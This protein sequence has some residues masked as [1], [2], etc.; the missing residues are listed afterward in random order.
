AASA[1]IA[2]RLQ[3]SRALADD[4]AA[5]DRSRT[6]ACAVAAPYGER[7]A[8]AAD[9]ARAGH[10]AAQ[11]YRRSVRRVNGRHAPL[12]Y[13]VDPAGAAADRARTDLWRR[14]LQCR[15]SRFRLYRAIAVARGVAGVGTG[16]GTAGRCGCVEDLVDLNQCADTGF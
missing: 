7:L 12:W 6:L 9:R 11:P 14:R 15:T 8:R 13:A 2:A 3:G 5:I 4:G 10:T 16:F 1:G